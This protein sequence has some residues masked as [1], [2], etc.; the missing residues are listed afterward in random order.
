VEVTDVQ[1]RAL[2]TFL[3]VISVA[4][5]GSVSAPPA[6]RR[7]T[8]DAGT[9]AVLLGESLVAVFRAQ[10]LQGTSHGL[11]VD[12]P[13]GRRYIVTGLAPNQA[14]AMNVSLVIGSTLSYVTFTP[15]SSG[16]YR[17]TAQGVLTVN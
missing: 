13:R 3:H 7:L 6:A 16:A 11:K 10:G 4:D 8:A 9:E 14:Y 1:P 2:S 15:S 5:D 12:N 17:T